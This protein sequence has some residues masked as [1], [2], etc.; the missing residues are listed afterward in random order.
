M[1]KSVALLSACLLAAALS[2]AVALAVVPGARAQSPA[3]PE[4]PSVAL[5][6]TVGT[7]PAVCATGDTITLPPGGGDVFYCYEVTNTGDHALNQHT[8]VDDQLGT[9][10]SGFTYHLSPGASAFLTQSAMIT[11]TTV[12]TATWTASNPG[13]IDV[14]VASDS[15]EVIVPVPAIVVTKTVGLDPAAC[16]P[17]STATLPVGGGIVT[18]CYEVANT[19]AV[20][21]TRHTLVD[22]RLGTILSNFHFTLVPGASVFLTQTATITSTTTNVAT[23]TASNPG[24]ADEVSAADS[25]TVIVESFQFLPFI[26]RD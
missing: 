13:P 18:Y 21:L 7:D 1:K 3:A 26:R 16:A 20:T 15:A 2:L 11:A 24:P 6:K 4:A 12:N 5:A 25:A 8:L 23:W 22:D 10:L 9:I 14:V 17:T 19:G